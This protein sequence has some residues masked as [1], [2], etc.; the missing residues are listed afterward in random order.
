MK[1]VSNFV[2]FSK[3]W[4]GSLTTANIVR[5][6]MNKSCEAWI[7]FSIELC[8]MIKRFRIFT[9]LVSLST[10]TNIYQNN[11]NF[12]CLLGNYCCGIQMQSFSLKTSMSWWQGCWFY[13]IQN[14]T[15]L[16]HISLKLHLK[17]LEAYK[18]QLNIKRF[19]FGRRCTYVYE[20]MLL[21]HKLSSNMIFFSLMMCFCSIVYYQK[22]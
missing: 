20:K 12:W 17:V 1:I 14:P 13:F 10:Y 4:I 9:F 18:I 3:Y 8:I 19:W 5:G 22:V 2:A 21:L 7:S 15:S 16:K 6:E 11:E